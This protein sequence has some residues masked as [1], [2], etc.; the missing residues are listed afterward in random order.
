[1]GPTIVQ[2]GVAIAI[3][4]LIFTVLQAISPSL[5]G[6]KILRPGI[7]T[8]LSYFAISPFITKNLT[9]IALVLTLVPIAF[10]MGM[11]LKTFTQGHGVVGAQTM[12]AQ[13][14]QIFVVSDFMRYWVH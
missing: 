2:L 12:P 4:G 9:Q 3:L 6:Q 13:A 8:D 11:D 7:L 14:I 10:A 1:M 5:R